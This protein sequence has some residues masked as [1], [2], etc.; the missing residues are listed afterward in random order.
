M[1]PVIAIFFRV[2]RSSIFLVDHQG[3]DQVGVWFDTAAP[4]LL[5][6]GN[7]QPRISEF[8][9]S[10]IHRSVIPILDMDCI[11]TFIQVTAAQLDTTL[12]MFYVS[13][14]LRTSFCV[15][16]F[17]PLT[18]EFLLNNIQQFSLYFTCAGARGN[19]VG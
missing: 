8:L 9:L 11:L 7:R 12:R 4:Q 10:Y 14:V 13:P 18:T 3:G 17:N 6:S 19:V 5:R 2:P 16:C 1:A 15:T